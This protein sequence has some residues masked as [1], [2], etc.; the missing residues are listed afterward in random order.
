MNSDASDAARVI[1][2]AESRS[3]EMEKTMSPAQ[4]EANRL[5]QEQRVRAREDAEESA[6][7]TAAGDGGVAT[8]W[9]AARTAFLRKEPKSAGACHPEKSS[10]TE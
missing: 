8:M 5:G 6:R 2:A 10:W 4:I 3:P 7:Q 1:H 9:I